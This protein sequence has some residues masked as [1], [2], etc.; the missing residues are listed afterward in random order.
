MWRRYAQWC[1]SPDAKARST[2]TRLGGHDAGVLSRSDWFSDASHCVEGSYRVWSAR[3][4]LRLGVEVSCEWMWVLP[5]AFASAGHGISQEEFTKRM[6][7]HPF[8][9]GEFGC[10]YGP[11]LHSVLRHDSGRGRFQTAA[12]AETDALGCWHIS[13]QMPR[14]R[15]TMDQHSSGFVWTRAFALAAELALF[16]HALYSARTSV[17]R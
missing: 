4:L 10:A 8:T 6:V 7:L 17:L 13:A 12:K 15:R 2:P 16:P 11:L 9:T 1:F 5:F 3:V 14:R